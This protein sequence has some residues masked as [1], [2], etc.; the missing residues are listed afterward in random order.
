[1]AYQIREE[2]MELVKL[3]RTFAE[4]ELKP[5]VAECDRKGEMPMD[6]YE[7]AFEIG[8]HL[9]EIPK[10]YG[11]LGLDYQTMYAVWEEIAKVDSGFATSLG[12]NS[13]ALKPILIAGNDEQK[14]YFAEFLTGERGN[15]FAA[16]A[17]TEANAG[18]DSAAGRTTA[19]RDGDEYVI[20][21]SK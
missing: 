6:V 4:K 9:M 8:F 16:F 12:A 20:N 13:L 15:C 21:G 11:G 18:S 1:M 7:K 17:L 10:E 3:A 5:V 14:K 2:E 19:V